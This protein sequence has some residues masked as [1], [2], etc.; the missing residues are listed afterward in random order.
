MAARRTAIVFLATGLLAIASGSQARTWRVERDGSGDFVVIQD[1]VDAAS[2]GDVIQLG[3]GRF[4]E[5]E[6]FPGY[7]GVDPVS[8]TPCYCG[9]ER[10]PRCRR[11]AP[12]THLSTATA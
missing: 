10:S 6:A 2:P 8:R 5:W 12:Y 4:D 11:N 3:P 1:A 9:S 7:P